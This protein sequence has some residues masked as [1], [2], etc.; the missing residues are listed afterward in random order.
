MLRSRLCRT[1]TRLKSNKTSWFVV[2][3]LSSAI[4]QDATMPGTA[5]SLAIRSIRVT[6]DVVTLHFLGDLWANTWADDDR[7]YLTFGDGTGRPCAP[8]VD[9]SRP[10]AFVSPW[11]G[12]TGGQTR[13]LSCRASRLHGMGS[14]AV[15]PDIRLPDFQ[16][17]L[18]ALPFHGFGPGGA[19]RSRA[20]F[21]EDKSARS[22]TIVLS[23]AI[24]Q[25]LVRSLSRQVT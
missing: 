3:F 15:L 18:Q 16:R 5:A 19:E 25:P 11:R 4:A 6:R 14:G 7:L 8:T 20:E 13:L 9:N 1:G 21:P 12:F 17:V 22:S 2:F 24:F 10:G 23:P